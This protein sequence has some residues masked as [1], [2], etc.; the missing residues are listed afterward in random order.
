ML[1]FLIVRTHSRMRKYT[2]TSHNCSS[3]D[4]FGDT[5]WLLS[6]FVLST[7]NAS[8]QTHTQHFSMSV[9]FH[10]HHLVAARLAATHAAIRTTKE[11][12]A[13]NTDSPLVCRA[14]GDSPGL[15]RGREKNKKIELK[16]H[17]SDIFQT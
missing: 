4:V 15:G 1:S 16:H 11:E 12:E 2:R 17:T 5:C 6:S 14:S 9:R 10:Y 3:T 7:R 8:Q 13:A